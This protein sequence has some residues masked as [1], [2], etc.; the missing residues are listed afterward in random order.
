[1][2]KEREVVSVSDLAR[3]LIVVTQASKYFTQSVLQV[4]SSGVYF[5]PAVTVSHVLAPHFKIIKW[6]SAAYTIIDLNLRNSENNLH[7]T[8]CIMTAF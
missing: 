5:H 3:M 2:K 4:E 7:I 6:L 1:M 8:S